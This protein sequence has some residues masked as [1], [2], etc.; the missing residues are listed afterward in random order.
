MRY[1][2]IIRLRVL[3]AHLSSA[4]F[5]NARLR[6]RDYSFA[7]CS[8]S[9]DNRILGDGIDNF[10][11]RR[12]RRLISPRT[13]DPRR[14]RGTL[15]EKETSLKCDRQIMTTSLEYA[16]RALP[17]YFRLLRSQY[18]DRERLNRCVNFNLLETLQVAAKI[19]FYVASYRGV[20]PLE[21][22]TRLPILKR[23]DIP[24]LN[25]AVRDCL[26]PGTRFSTDWSSGSTGLPAEFLFDVAHQ[27]GR[28]AA[29]AR[30]LREN[31]WTPRRRTAW[32]FR[33][34]FAADDSDD[35]RLARARLFAANNFFP[36]PEQ[37]HDLY[38]W[39]RAIDP[40]F[41]YIF[42]SYLEE[43][44]PDFENGPPLRNLRVIFTG[45]E[46]L[47]DS[48]RRRAEK[49]FGTKLLDI[50]GATEAFVAWQCSNENY[51]INAEHVLVEIVDTE[52]RSVAPGEMG[53]VLVTTL[54]NRVMPLVRYEIGDYAIAG[55]DVCGCGRTLPLLGKIIGR[56]LSLFTLR[57]GRLT[58]PWTLVEPV[59]VQRQINQFQI[60]QKTTEL[61]VIRYL[62]E[63]VL[64][65]EVKARVSSAFCRILG[66][67]VSVEFQKVSTI[68]RTATG[69]YMVALS[70]IGGMSPPC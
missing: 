37:Y 57:D 29:R 60:V 40:T 68:P 13:D 26:K 1:L 65:D 51:H 2:L 39:L 27:V 10:A 54:E 19:P 28:F 61:F 32:V 55:G 52:G 41:L 6:R 18:W 16:A 35:V 14:L 67:A 59:K 23:R 7:Q 25:R 62:A 24:D 47:D 48:L 38:N 53:R 17:R 46:V 64:S 50:Y 22:F 30:F 58:S 33:F 44:L 4:G 3:E 43:V 36:R 56:G 9:P 45:A 70:E 66:Y 34:N 5:W 63:F 8:R 69:K 20:A 49:V 12:H 21:D 31:G 15:T 11:E 42:P